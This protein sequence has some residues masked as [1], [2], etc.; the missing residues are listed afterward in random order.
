MGDLPFAGLDEAM[1]SPELEAG[2]IGK[3]RNYVEAVKNAY[4][5]AGEALPKVETPEGELTEVEY[6]RA[7]VDSMVSVSDSAPKSSEL[8]KLLNELYYGTG[9]G[10]DV[11]IPDD[12]ELAAA[13]ISIDDLI[14]MKSVT[15]HGGPRGNVAWP[16]GLLIKLLEPVPSQ[17]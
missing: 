13:G 6:L 17:V 15:S 2:V 9:I 16:I 14:Q 11:E 5:Q 4:T 3:L 8:N 10:A 12:K 1:T 7:L